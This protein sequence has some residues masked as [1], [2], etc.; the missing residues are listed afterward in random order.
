MTNHLIDEY[1]S[2]AKKPMLDTA[3]PANKHAQITIGDMHANALKFIYF[4]V[5]HGVI[6]NMTDE[7]YETFV[8]IYMKNID[9]LTAAD[10]EEFNLILDSLKFNTTATVRLIGDELCDRGANDYFILKLFQKLHQ[11]KVPIETMLS[12]HGTEFLLAHETKNKF[13]PTIMEPRHTTSMTN[14]QILIARKLV[15]YEEITSIVNEAYKPYN[16]LLSYT[17]SRDKKSI[18]LYSHAPV[19]VGIVKTLAAK[20]NVPFSDKTPVSLGKTIHGIN[21]A[22]AKHLADKTVHTLLSASV[23]FNGYDVESID[24]EKYPVEFIIWN[25]DLGILNRSS[26]HNGYAIS[27]I[28]GHDNQISANTNV[29]VLDNFLGKSILDNEGN[30][31]AVFSHERKLNLKSKKSRFFSERPERKSNENA[32]SNQRT[33]PVI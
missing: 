27:Y 29:F 32:A 1:V 23:L 6:T 19:D 26:I 21:K 4:L 28:H 18:S 10:L 15:T 14:L 17:L 12:N 31:T 25:R 2:I 13:F 20:L 8:G 30:Y 3:H 33:L 24:P 22:F 9:A 5:R 7:Q 16:K 11:H